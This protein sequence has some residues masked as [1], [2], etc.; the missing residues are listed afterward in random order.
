MRRVQGV[1]ELIERQDV[2]YFLATVPDDEADVEPWAA[3][4]ECVLFDFPADEAAGIARELWEQVGD[5]LWAEEG[6]PAFRALAGAVRDVALLREERDR[7]NEAQRLLVG[8]EPDRYGDAARSTLTPADELLFMLKLRR[9]RGG[10]ARSEALHH[11]A[12][13][14]RRRARRRLKVTS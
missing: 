14:A 11:R 9:P 13:A 8:A 1:L 3:L 6:E 4:W 5:E 12:E 10:F 2:A 7:E